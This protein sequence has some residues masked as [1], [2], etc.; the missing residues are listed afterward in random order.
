MLIEDLIAEYY[1]DGEI[2]RRLRSRGVE[3][4][5]TFVRKVRNDMFE[6]IS[7]PADDPRWDNV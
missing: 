4:T 2:V 6:P 1:D 5:I 7:W 3:V